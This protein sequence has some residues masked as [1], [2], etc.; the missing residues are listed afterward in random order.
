MRKKRGKKGT[1]TTNR[2]D[3]EQVF[4]MKYK[5]EVEKYKKTCTFVSKWGM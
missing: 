5:M 1:I 3:G 4:K 2:G